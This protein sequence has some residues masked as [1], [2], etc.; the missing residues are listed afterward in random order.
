MVAPRV[1]V[2]YAANTT[3][4]Y[5]VMN[6]PIITEQVYA[7]Y[8][9]TGLISYEGPKASV[10]SDLGLDTIPCDRGADVVDGAALSLKSGVSFGLDVYNTPTLV[11]GHSSAKLKLHGAVTEITDNGVKKNELKIR[12][13]TWGSEQ[14]IE[15]KGCTAYTESGSGSKKRKSAFAEIDFKNLLGLGSFLS[16]EGYYA[17]GSLKAN[18]VSHDFDLKLKIMLPSDP[19]SLPTE[20]CKSNWSIARCKGEVQ[21]C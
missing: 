13:N 9:Q 14:Y 17:Y 20:R 19:L 2:S 15:I 11:P 1:D 8:Q 5:G 3:E 10:G 7:K 18:G 16:S 6:L 12:S 21:T 4:H